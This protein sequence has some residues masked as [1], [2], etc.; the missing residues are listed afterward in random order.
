MSNIS[1]LLRSAIFVVRI[2]ISVRG[3]CHI[4]GQYR[5]SA[6][7]DFTLKLR[8]NPGEFKIPVIFHNLRGYDSHFIMRENGSIGK[9]HDLEINCVPNNME[10]YMAFMLVKYIVF[11]DSFQFMASSLGRLA[12]N[13]PEDA[14]KY[15]SQ[16][17][18]DEKLTLMKQKGVHP[19]DCMDSFKTFD[20]Q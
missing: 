3:D 1:K 8:I 9:E 4:T 14:F 12:A 10:K 11:L 2:I 20:D 13:L 17:F 18:Q 6:H 5:G 19:Y 7:Q 15:T 16:V